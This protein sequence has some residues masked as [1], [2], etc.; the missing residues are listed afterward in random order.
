M[1]HELLRKILDFAGY[2]ASF[3]CVLK[4]DNH[5][6]IELAAFLAVLLLVI[7]SVIVAANKADHRR[8]K[9]H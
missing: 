5:L 7:V 4:A 3:F 1:L 9:H 8:H 6:F 2:L